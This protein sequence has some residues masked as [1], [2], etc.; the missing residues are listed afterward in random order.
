MRALALAHAVGDLADLEHRRHFATH[1]MEF[2]GLFEMT[3][4]GLEI[5]MHAEE[6]SV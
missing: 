5:A 4:K 1:A 6:D 2:A 3:E